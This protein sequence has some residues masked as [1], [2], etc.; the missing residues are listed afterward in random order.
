MPFVKGEI[1]E[2]AKPFKLGKSGNYNGRPRKL[3]E[4][5]KILGQ[6]LSEERN[7]KTAIEEI[8]LALLVK[9]FKGEA[10]AAE[11]ILNRAYGKPKE[12]IDITSNE[13]S[14]SQKPMQI[15]ILPAKENFEIREY[16]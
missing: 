11:I 14:I 8:L 16:E 13:E 2:G 4:L 9:A 10:R 7:G 5:D 12:R 6:V 15:L 3:P 1:P